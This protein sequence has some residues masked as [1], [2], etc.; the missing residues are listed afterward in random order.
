MKE[1]IKKILRE[2]VQKRFTKSNPNFERI[3]IKFMEAM[4]VVKKP[5]YKVLEMLVQ[6]QL[7]ILPKWEQKLWVSSTV[8]VES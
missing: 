4:F 2:E 6:R 5:S 1:L 7:F 3:I 8:M